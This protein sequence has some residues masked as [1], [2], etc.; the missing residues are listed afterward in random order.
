MTQN[1]SLLK[2]RV[3][4]FCSNFVLL[5]LRKLRLKDV[6]SLVLLHGATE[7]VSGGNRG[8]MYIVRVLVL[9]PGH[10]H[11]VTGTHSSQ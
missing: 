9:F 6:G 10:P 8:E 2:E 5:Y 11:L 3:A 7:T 1:I 4:R